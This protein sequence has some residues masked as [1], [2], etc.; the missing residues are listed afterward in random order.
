MHLCLFQQGHLS[1]QLISHYY[2]FKPLLS[3]VIE[4]FY[5]SSLTPPPFLKG[6]ILQQQ[7]SSRTPGTLM[8]DKIHGPIKKVFLVSSTL[9]F[10]LPCSSNCVMQPK[11]ILLLSRYLLNSLVRM[12]YVNV[13]NWNER[14]ACCSHRHRCLWLQCCL[15]RK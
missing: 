5:D 14:R 13:G 12:N 4:N 9:S 7:A 2:F 11:R 15:S 10:S 1:H 6:T 3:L 8:L